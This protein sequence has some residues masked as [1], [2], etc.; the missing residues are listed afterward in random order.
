[1][2]QAATEK[3]KNF[4]CI[5]FILSS[6]LLYIVLTGS[7]NLYVAEK[8]TLET[9]GFGSYIELAMTME[10][11][12]YAYAAMQVLLIFFMKRI[13]V[14]WFLTATISVSALLTIYVAFSQTLVE[15]YVIYIANG[16]LQAGIWGCLLKLISDSLPM[17]FLPFANKLMSAGPAVA[18]IVSY[19]TAAAFGDEWR[20]PFIVLGVLLLLAVGLYF[21]AATKVSRMPKEEDE[22]VIFKANGTRE[23]VN[24]REENDFIHL[25]SRLR[26]IIFYIVAAIMSFFITSLFFMLNNNIDAFFKEI[27]GFSNDIA[28][29]IT[30]LVPISIVIGPIVTV[31][32]C[33]KHKN[34]ILVGAVYFGISALLS[35]LIVFLYD[36]H[37]VISTILLLAFLIVC[38]G[39]RTITLSI[40]AIKMRKKIDT[41]VFSTTVNATSSIASGFAPRFLASIL[42]NESLSVT[43]SWQMSFISVFALNAFIVVAILLIELWVY[44]ANR[45]KESN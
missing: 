15:H 5:I 10:Y 28:K 19:G 42:D 2:K 16:F 37:I 25:D 41:G 27:G 7:K 4:W 43:E 45:K 34:F 6:F 26:V 11:Y 18:G 33:E 24:A 3:R 44:L 17:R 22:L 14:K 21:F 9:L 23:E 29:L 20:T 30:I 1:M 31:N 40:V 13:N 8:T 36:A 32:S 38:N 39:A 35:L 12:F